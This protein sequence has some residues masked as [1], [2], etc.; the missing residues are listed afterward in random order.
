[1]WRPKLLPLYCPS[2]GAGAHHPVAGES[3]SAA[4][5]LPAAAW[6]GPRSKTGCVYGGMLLGDG[7]TLTSVYGPYAIIGYGIWSPFEGSLGP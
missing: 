6:L 5:P 4:S 3:L 2:G 1:M 7:M